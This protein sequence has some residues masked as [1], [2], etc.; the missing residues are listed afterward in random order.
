[1]SEI[2][3]SET[4][5]D[6]F[7]ELFERGLHGIMENIIL[8]LPPRIIVACREVNKGWRA[9]LHYYSNSKNETFLKKRDVRLDQEWRKKD[10][11]IKTICL[12][13][14]GIF[15]VKC[16]HMIGDVNQIVVAA[17][18]NETKKA[19]VIVL[20]AKTDSVVKILDVTDSDDV[21]IDVNEIKMSLKDNF[22]VA[23]VHES[24]T[25]NRF[26]QVWKRNEDFTVIPHRQ[27]CKPEWCKI[28]SS[29]LANVPFIRNGSLFIFIKEIFDKW[30]GIEYEEW[31]LVNNTRKIIQE[32]IKGGSNVL[33]GGNWFYPRVGTGNWKVFTHSENGGFHN[34]LTVVDDTIIWREG[35]PLFRSS[36]LIA[37]YTDN[38][39]AVAGVYGGRAQGFRY[40]NI[41]VGETQRVIGEVQDYSA[42][43][44]S[45]DYQI[46][47]SYPRFAMLGG[48]WPT[49]DFI[50]WAK[51][52]LLVWDLSSKKKLFR[53]IPDFG[54]KNL[55]CFTIL[56]H[57]ICLENLNT[58]YIL[59]FSAL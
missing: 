18:I 17:A 30:P 10:P 13:K 48:I 2:T 37:G 41:E 3:N 19:K 12:E 27:E 35:V 39:L 1:M 47:F 22:L 31:N 57:A 59:K 20:D 44:G 51:I 45:H 52:D 25:E 58:L 23:Y 56:K 7:T 21:E 9:I 11:I 29:Y 50:T 8:D 32:F 38:Y 33:P 28:I 14:F 54:F 16:F 42:G 55:G 49:E 6:F 34:H 26:Y 5:I 40:Y 36:N 53:C 15:N 24:D 43:Y 46:Q 4:K